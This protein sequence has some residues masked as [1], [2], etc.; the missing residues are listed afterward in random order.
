MGCANWQ[1]VFVEVEK[2]THYAVWTYQMCAPNNSRP[3]AEEVCIGGD[4]ED[5]CEKGQV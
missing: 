1:L 3:T 4:K 2:G 5:L